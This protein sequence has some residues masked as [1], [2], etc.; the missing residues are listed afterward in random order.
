MSKSSSIRSDWSTGSAPTDRPDQGLLPEILPAKRSIAS[1]LLIGSFARPLLAFARSAHRL[2]VKPY[3]IELSRGRPMW[4]KYSRCL[5]GGTCLNPDLVGTDAGIAFIKNYARVVGADALICDNDC[6]PAWISDHRFQFEPDTI[7]MV[8]SSQSMETLRC[9]T[10]QL[11]LA[12]RVGF[13]VL[14]TYIIRSVEDCTAVPKEAYPICLRPSIAKRIQPPFKAIVLTSPDQLR[15]FLSSRTNL[16]GGIVAQPF[17]NA[18]NLLVHGVRSR[19]GEMVSLKC[20]LVDRKFEGIAL[21]LTMMAMPS[22]LSDLCRRFAEQADVTACFHFDLLYSTSDG[23]IYFLEINDRP[24][25]TTDMVYKLAY[26]EFQYTLAAHGLVAR[27]ER[28]LKSPTARR[29]ANKRVLLKYIWSTFRRRLTDLDYP[30]ATPLD[31]LTSSLRE[32]VLATD[33]VF[34]WQDL[35]GS[36]WYHSRIS[37]HLQLLRPSERELK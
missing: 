37:Q 28:R 6:P 35:R 36:R 3:L 25:G 15:A 18:P 32:L 17:L 12:K 8:T 14:P 24:G 34:D 4:S 21:S 23:K 31:R 29:V 5:T 30:R 27:A 10:H 1:V 2:G 11:D 26:D 16:E 9:K 19:S 33:S 22:G 13:D 7:V 20:F